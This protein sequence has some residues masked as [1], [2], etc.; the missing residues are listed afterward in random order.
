MP[1]SLEDEILKVR[2]QAKILAEEA[3]VLQENANERAKQARER[4]MK[5]RERLERLLAGGALNGFDLP[6]SAKRRGRS[7]RPP[8]PP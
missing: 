6:P 8:E 2:G 4:A 7:R 5:A 1:G 3:R